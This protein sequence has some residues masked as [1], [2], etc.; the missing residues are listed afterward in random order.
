LRV[1][2]AGFA[3]GSGDGGGAGIGV[4]NAVAVAPDAAAVAIALEVGVVGAIR[5]L[6][7]HEFKTMATMPARQ[8]SIIEAKKFETLKSN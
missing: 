3:G 2:C 4:F 7:D 5:I 1:G 6:L 8:S